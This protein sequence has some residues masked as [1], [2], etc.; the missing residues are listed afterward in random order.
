MTGRSQPKPM[1]IL[2][3][4]PYDLAVP[5]GVNRHAL[6]LLESLTAR[7]HTAKLVGPASSAVFEHDERIVRLGRVWTGGFNG[8]VSRITLDLRIGPA[9]KALMRGFRP[10]VVHVQEPFAPILS[11][12]VLWHAGKARRVGTF[13]TYSDRSRGYL[14][15]W[16]W[17]RW[18]N[19]RLDA[20]I[21]VSASAREYAAQYH[22]AH[23]EL[24]SNGVRLPP[25]SAVR[26]ESPPSNPVR[27]LFVGR[28][29]EPRKGFAVLRD[30]FALLEK[31]RP[32]A[33]S[34]SAVGPD[35][36]RAG[37][38]P[39]TWLGKLGDAELSAAYARA[40]IVVAPSLGGESFGLVALE[41]LA[42][43]VPV[44]A[45]R[46][47]GYADWLEG[48]EVGALVPPGDAP[49]LAA[50]LRACAADPAHY[51]LCAAKARRLASRF[52][53]NRQL[54]RILEIYAPDTSKE[55][56]RG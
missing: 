35:R 39:V 49:A 3:S 17:C 20:R 13:H 54:E 50:A 45:S 6:D 48:E 52:D 19:A 38:L 22:P 56:G 29:D 44:V 26:P 15:A 4:S 51:A 1:R 25:L 7:G 9:V 42:H 21:A 5:G 8:A 31:E 27:L 28:A 32:G 11:A 30:A 16:P 46:I 33:F 53:W 47:R 12:F 34:L 10:D 41:A 40:D 36:P 24:I 14:I 18:I 43:G 2:I 23:Y 55:L 37:G